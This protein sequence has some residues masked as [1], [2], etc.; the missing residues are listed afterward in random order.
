[1]IFFWGEGFSVG[2]GVEYGC[3]LFFCF[4]KRAS[5]KKVTGMGWFK[6]VVG[7]VYVYRRMIWVLKICCLK[8]WGRGGKRGPF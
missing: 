4:K 6:M 2:V 5:S 1:M 3:S 7:K 8:H